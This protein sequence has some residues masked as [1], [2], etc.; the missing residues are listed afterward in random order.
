MTGGIQPEDRM[1]TTGPGSGPEPLP[2][3]A[4]ARG[5]RATSG[6]VTE[7]GSAP[8]LSTRSTPVP[9]GTRWPAPGVWPITWPAGAVG[10]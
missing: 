8:L 4:A 2:A 3:S 10:W 7:A 6:T 9:A 1:T 5:R